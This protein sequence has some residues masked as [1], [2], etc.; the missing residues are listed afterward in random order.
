MALFYP[1]TLQSNN[2]NAYGIIKSVEVVG[3]KR[4]QALSD[5]YTLS[6]CILSESGDNTNNDAIGQLW[7]VTE[8]NKYYQLVNWDNR[9]QSSGWSEYVSNYNDLENKPDLSQYVTNEQFTEHTSATNPHNITKDLIQ[10]GN[11]DNTSDV[12]K[13]VSTAQQQAI[14]NAK[15]EVG[16][17]TINGQKISTNPALDKTNIGLGNVDNTSDLDKPISTA[18]QTALDGKQDTLVSGVNIKTINGNNITGAGNIEIDAEINTPTATAVSVDSSQDPTVSVTNNEGTWNFDFKIPKGEQGTAGQNLESIN[19]SIP[20]SITDTGRFETSDTDLGSYTVQT[21]SEQIELGR[22]V[23]IKFS[24]KSATVTSANFSDSRLILTGNIESFSFSAFISDTTAS[25]VVAEI[26]T[27]VQSSGKLPPSI[28]P[29]ATT[30]KIGAVSV[31]DNL[32]VTPEGQLSVGSTLINRV[33]TVEE[34]LTQ[35]IINFADM[36][37]ITSEAI[38]STFK[39]NS[40]FQVKVS[41]A[42]VGT[43]LVSQDEGV[44]IQIFTGIVE[45]MS[46]PTDTLGKYCIWK[47]TDNSGSE[48]WTPWEQIKDYQKIDITNYNIVGD[49]YLNA[50]ISSSN[51]FIV[52][53]TNVYC[54]ISILYYADNDEWEIRYY[55]KNGQQNAL[56]V[57]STL[58][59]TIYGISEIK[60]KE[61]SQDWYDSNTHDTSTLYLITS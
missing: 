20:L 31:G 40:F 2:P 15:Q 46:S 59:Y 13:P 5:L 42:V 41:D 11:V 8:Q 50:P 55:D 43:L 58:K 1:D 60:L 48:S 14:D 7:Y 18:T 38:S 19:I 23:T 35:G 17:Y 56:S 54:P 4:V 52:S 57:L 3:H 34:R 12:N 28:L 47:R 33:A 37:N 9:K 24:N 10:L 53:D 39:G 25:V 27:T 26:V 61:V 49:N 36:D 45:D 22:V 32:D 16:N 30:S 21:L 51:I 44:D 6:D 29:T